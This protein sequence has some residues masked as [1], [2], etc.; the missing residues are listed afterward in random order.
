MNK[1][2]LLFTKFLSCL[3][4]STEY[5][6]TENLVHGYSYKIY[7]RNAYVGIWHEGEK[8]FLISRYSIGNTPYLFSEYHWDKDKTLGTA[9][10]LELIEKSPFEIKFTWEYNLKETQAILDYL[11]DLEE[12]NPLI[13]GFNS[14]LDRKESAINC[15][16][17]QAEK[18]RKYN[19]T[20][21]DK[22]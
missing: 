19:L 22:F 7:A 2:E 10:P 9:K 1:K 15:S 20:A 16:I 14:L 11:D 4:K 8:S 17:K 18:I 6:K 12:R 13:I 3:Q 5:L 21:N